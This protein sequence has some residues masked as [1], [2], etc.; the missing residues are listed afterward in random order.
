MN[1]EWLYNLRRGKNQEK[2]SVTN[3]ANE[4][5]LA[6]LLSNNIQD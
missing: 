3:S 2:T 1:V 4:A 5:Q 6:S